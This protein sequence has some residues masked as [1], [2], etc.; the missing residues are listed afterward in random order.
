MGTVKKLSCAIATL[1]SVGYLPAP[2]TCGTIC[3]MF[4]IY[5]LRSM[6]SP[7]LVLM[8]VAILTMGA[9]LA[10]YC[11]LPSFSGQHDPS[12]IVIDEFIGFSMLA[13]ILPL[14]PILF[15]AGFSLFR[16]FDIVKPFGIKSIER[17]HGVMGIMFDDIAAAA[18]A[19]LG[20]LGVLHLLNY[21][22]N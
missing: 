1:G 5:A 7:S 11:A 6:L 18:Y 17:L 20:V 15:F 16:F 12:Q 21:M 13:S 22:G 10:V 8:I 9:F 14:N 3:A 19:G 4:F 2:G